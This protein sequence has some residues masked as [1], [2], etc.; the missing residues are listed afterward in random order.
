MLKERPC[1]WVG[2]NGW[3]KSRFTVVSMQNT[4]VIPVLLF[5]V[6]FS[7]WT[8]VT[9]LLTHPVYIEET[10]VSTFWSIWTFSYFFQLDNNPHEGR[11]CLSWIY[12]RTTWLTQRLARCSERLMLKRHHS[13][14]AKSEES[15]SKWGTP[16]VV[17]NLFRKLLI[18]KKEWV[19]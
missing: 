13:P 19:R 16:W 4:E 6:W 5:T 7:I 15:K 3:D 10:W 17:E 9:L 12:L 2:Y 18:K 8:A 11:E 14:L 1:D